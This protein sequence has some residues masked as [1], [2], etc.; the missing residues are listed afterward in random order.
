MA[1]NKAGL[2]YNFTRK[3]KS[4]FISIIVY[5]EANWGVKQAQEYKNLIAEKI[6]FLCQMP[7]SGVARDELFKG[8][9]SSPVGSHKIYYRVKPKQL[10]IIAILHQSAEPQFHLNPS[11]N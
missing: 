8:L 5:T 9:R 10:E 4:D 7:E 1:K 2:R 11:L 3:A 6:N